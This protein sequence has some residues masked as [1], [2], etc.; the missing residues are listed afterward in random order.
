MYTRSTTNGIEF[1]SNNQTVLI[2][3][4][5]A[6]TLHGIDLFAFNK[7]LHCMY[8]IISLVDGCGNMSHVM[9][10]DHFVH[11]QT[12]NGSCVCF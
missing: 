7:M 10:H 11:S 1:V 5:S 4:F 12:S 2:W 3:L 6:K 8:L 9:C